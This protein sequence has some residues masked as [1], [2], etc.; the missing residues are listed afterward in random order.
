MKGSQKAANGHKN[1]FP[2]TAAN[3]VKYLRK[4]STLA[5]FEPVHVDTNCFL[6]LFHSC[7]IVA[8]RTSAGISQLFQR[9]NFKTN[10]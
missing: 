4:L 9:S 6:K 7:N 2:E 1:G 10:F 8:F 5:V 3:S